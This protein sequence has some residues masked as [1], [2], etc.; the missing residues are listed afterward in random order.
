MASKQKQKQIFSGTVERPGRKLQLVA[1]TGKVGGTA[2]FVTRAA[3]NIDLV[4]LPASQSASKFVIPVTG[5]KVGDVITGFSLA[6]QIES[7]GGAVTLDAELRKM[8]AA[9]ADVA[10]ASVGSMTQIAVTAD[11]AITDANS[12]KTGLSEI[13]GED[14]SFYLLITGTTAA[15]TDVCLQSAKIILTEQ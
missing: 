15:S 9:A 4:T 8:T 5:L 6:G 14:E 2:G 1:S 10:D 7:A 3:S 12:T 11:T 13:V